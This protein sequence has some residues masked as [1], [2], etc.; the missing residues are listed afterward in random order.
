MKKLSIILPTYNIEKHILQTVKS[1]TEQTYKNLEIIV[2][3]DNSSDET[4]NIIKEIASNDD[5]IKIFRNKKNI[6]PGPSRNLGIKKSTGYYITFMDHDDWQNLDRYEK[7]IQQIEDDGTDLCL[8][9]A[10]DFIEDGEKFVD[11]GYPKFETGVINFKKERSKF[12]H[13]FFPPWS[14]IYKADLIKKNNIKFAEYGVKFDDVLFHSLLIFSINKAS[15]YNEFNYFHRV[16]NN[17]ITYKFFEDKQFMRNEYL[18]SMKQAL[19][20][21]P[22]RKIIKYYLK[23]VSL[24]KLSNSNLLYIFKK[25]PLFFVLSAKIWP[26][27]IKKT[28]N[29]D[30]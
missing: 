14:K 5:R 19:E 11:T 9:Y 27:T 30:K 6:G 21:N 29:L 3:D 12:F 25:N 20:I 13:S 10:K 28:L 18:S 22:S 17:S 24:K 1:I 8:S 16:F 7:M 26:K 15:I 4:L 23:L 2:I